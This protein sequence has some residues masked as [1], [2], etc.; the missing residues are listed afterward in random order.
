MGE[1]TRFSAHGTK[2]NI[3]KFLPRRMINFRK[4]IIVSDISRLIE[5]LSKLESSSSIPLCTECRKRF[6]SRDF[7]HQLY[8][9]L[10]TTSELLHHK[11]K[12]QN[13]Q[14]V[15][16]S[17]LCYSPSHDHVVR[18]SFYPFFSHCF[19]RLQPI[20]RPWSHHQDQLPG[21]MLGRAFDVCD[22]GSTNR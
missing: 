20:T 15:T 22:H 14:N 19:H 17:W 9:T 8:K 18:L 16:F 4:A 21:E 6:H 5:Y 12:T 2:L 13:Q 7:I 1:F 10:S 3:S 11:A